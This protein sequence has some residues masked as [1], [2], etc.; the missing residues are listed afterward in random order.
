MNWLAWKARIYAVGALCLGIITV[1][2]RMKFVTN[3][4]DK[5]K[6]DAEVY[7]LQV[8]QAQLNDAADSE[9]EQT[10][11]RRA[12]EAEEAIEDGQVPSNIRNP[13]DW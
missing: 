6:A 8:K 11:S 3:Q 4:R 13:N 5:F 12:H 1:I 9:I 7:K 2:I 10:F